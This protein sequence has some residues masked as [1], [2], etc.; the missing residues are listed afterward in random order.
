[1]PPHPFVL[2]GGPVT[3]C[4]RLVLLGAAVTMSLFSPAGAQETRAPEDKVRRY[5]TRPFEAWLADLQDSGDENRRGQAAMAMSGGGPDVIA[6]LLSVLGDGSFFVT[7]WAKQGLSYQGARA[8]PGLL[9]ALEDT[10]RKRADNAAI[11]LGGMGRPAQAVLLG[12]LRDQRSRMRARAADAFAWSKEWDADSVVPALLPLLRDSVLAVRLAAAHSIPRFASWNVRVAPSLIT[13]AAEP[14]QELR[15]AAI[16]ALNRLDTLPPAGAARIVA[17]L[18][19]P[20]CAVRATAAEALRGSQT[21]LGAMDGLLSLLRGDPEPAAVQSD[22]AACA[23]A[24]RWALTT[25]GEVVEL[26]DST[27]Y[28]KARQGLKFALRDPEPRVRQ[29]ALG[30]LR[31]LWDSAVA[32]AVLPLLGDTVPEVR[33]RTLHL[34]ASRDSSRSTIRI[35]EGMLRDSSPTVRLEAATDLAALAPEGPRILA[36]FLTAGDRELRVIVGYVMSPRDSLPTVVLAQ[37]DRLSGCQVERRT[38]GIAVPAESLAGRYRLTMIGANRPGP[39]SDLPGAARDTLTR[40]TLEFWVPDTLFQ[41][42]RDTTG[43]RFSRT[44]EYH[45]IAGAT[46]IDPGP[47]GV[48]P[49]HFST[50]SRDPRAPGVIVSAPLARGGERPGELRMDVGSRWWPH[51]GLR[52]RA[53]AAD[54]RRIRG[55]WY[56]EYHGPEVVAIGLWCAERGEISPAR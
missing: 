28:A 15:D 43:Q 44:T 56:H 29:E 51:H 35:A 31:S 9:E 13:L 14:E 50:T 17:A 16:V 21:E 48:A 42:P 7:S 36:H 38:G 46:D 33:S 18:R 3:P 27:L 30:G 52:F 45:P 22:P 1:M 39:P 12:L 8:I 2:L 41:Y 32:V 49:L 5:L 40:G 25:L 20:D 34:L 6:P 47:V 24:K 23:E 55:S 37:L 4:S 10:L 26:E 11:A 19:D 53:F 54:D